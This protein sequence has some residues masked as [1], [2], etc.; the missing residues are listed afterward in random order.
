M[1]EFLCSNKKFL[2]LTSL[3]VLLSALT[4]LVTPFIVQNVSDTLLISNK[5]FLLIFISM[6]LSFL[7]QLSAQLYRENYAANFN[8]QY[9]FQLLE[10]MSKLS[11]DTY[12]EAEPTYLINRIYQAVDALYLFF[13]NSL[14]EVLK[15]A[16]LLFFSVLF[17][18]FISWKI[19]ITLLLL[20]PLNYFGYK[21]INKELSVRMENMQQSSA[22]ALKDLTVTL[23]NVDGIKSQANEDM[24]YYLLEHKI[25]AMYVA[26][27]NAN[28]FAQTTSSILGF[29]NQ[30]SQQ[31][32]YL[33]T[34]LMIAKGE[35]E[36]T[37]LIVLSIVL[38]LF[39]NSLSEVNRINLD[40]RSLNTSNQYIQNELDDK[41]EKNGHLDLV[42]IQSI[43]F[44]K[45][46]FMQGT[47]KFDF[48][49]TATLSKNDIVYLSGPSGS[50][51]SS[52]LKLLLKFRPTEGIYINNLPINQLENRSLRQ[53]IAYLSQETTILSTTLEKNIG[54][55]NL[56]TPEQKHFLIQ[57]KLLEPILKNKN[58]ETMLVE[59]GSNLSGGEKQRIAAA[60]LLI[61]SADLYIMDESTSSIDEHSA[62]AIFETILNFKKD[63]II[64]FTS[65]DKKK[66]QYA[67]K[68]IEIG[69]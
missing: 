61:T 3:V 37:N 5:T 6:T 25:E 18:S 8:R 53:K 14:P 23:S 45:P 51:K 19:A 56:L 15:T 13:I 24:L 16:L 31:L 36:I 64:I 39:F 42:G 43:R 26:L 12:L 41:V 17:S 54:Y 69:K 47:K 33:W 27:A 35:L 9:L 68:I 55:G 11:Y 1:K 28:K 20:I 29:I 10:K 59:N 48:N 22:V 34:S 62:T 66:Q 52:L 38:P 57:T 40:F 58:W 30:L 46:T 32:I 2:I 7:L 4:A 21:T 50:G 65:H 67:T 49:I 44:A 63:K 60:R